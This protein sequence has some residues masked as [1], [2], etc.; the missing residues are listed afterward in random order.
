MM[1]AWV[2]ASSNRPCRTSGRI[3][4]LAAMCGCPAAMSSS[5]A[6]RAVLRAPGRSPAVTAISVTM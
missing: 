6:I 3:G 2:S 4:L 1:A 5:W